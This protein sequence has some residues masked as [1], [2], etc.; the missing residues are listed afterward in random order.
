MTARYGRCQICGRRK[1]TA[2]DGRIVR[3]YYK[4][5]A[6]RGSGSLPFDEDA[7]AIEAAIAH[8]QSVDDALSAE[9]RAHRRAGANAPFARL[10]DLQFAIAERLRLQRRLRRWNKLYGDEPSPTSPTQTKGESS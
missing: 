1:A 5:G 4:G 2:R 10:E 3:H 9:W 6:C 8:Y 7:G